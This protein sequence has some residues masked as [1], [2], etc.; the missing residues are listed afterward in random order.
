MRLLKTHAHTSERPGYEARKN[1]KK[2]NWRRR[3]HYN[4]AKHPSKTWHVTPVWRGGQD[5]KGAMARQTT[6]FFS[7]LPSTPFVR[8]QRVSPYRAAYYASLCWLLTLS[9]RRRRRE[10][11]SF[12]IPRVSRDGIWDVGLSP[13]SFHDYPEYK[14]HPN[15]TKTEYYLFLR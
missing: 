3:S 13:I 4:K 1:V 8:W 10:R 7:I 5:E 15:N 9:L 2:S 14:R 6:D 11:T 12:I